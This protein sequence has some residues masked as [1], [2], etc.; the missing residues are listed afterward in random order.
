MKTRFILTAVGSALFLAGC[1][2]DMWVQPRSKAQQPS[3]FFNDRM[4]SRPP[5]P[6]TVAYGKAKLDDGY[7]K[8]RVNGVLV[9]KVPAEKA[10]AD[11]KLKNY[12]EFLLRGK[13]RFEIYCTPCHGG[14]GD[15]K[16]MIA[17]RGLELK[18]SPGNYHT[19]RLR[20]I[21]DGHLFDVITNGYGVMYSYASRVETA[22]RW[23][24]VAYVRVLQQSRNMSADALPAEERAKL[25]AG[26]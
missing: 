15:G 22:D 12:K 6:G 7:Y 10:M 2:T 16:G 14:V 20:T 24:I 9:A 4:A 1:H 11:L 26:H 25:E 19:D 21:P 5:V 3:D 8:G 23:A 13:E 17:Q 18:R